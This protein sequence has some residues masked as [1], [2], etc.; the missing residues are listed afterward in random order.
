[1]IWTILG[2]HLK[3]PHSV[4]PRHQ[5][6]ITYREQNSYETYSTY[7]DMFPYSDWSIIMPDHTGLALFTI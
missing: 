2:L 5:A 6:E 1:M 3:H 7:L 4:T